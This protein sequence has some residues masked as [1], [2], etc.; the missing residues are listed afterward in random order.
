MAL[1]DTIKKTSKSLKFQRMLQ[2]SPELA[3]QSARNRD[4][5]ALEYSRAEALGNS[6][7]FYGPAV[8]Q[9]YDPN[10]L[11]VDIAPID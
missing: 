9:G 11:P 6:A 7:A 1:L 3:R 8:L 2:Y 4:K 5:L 10:A